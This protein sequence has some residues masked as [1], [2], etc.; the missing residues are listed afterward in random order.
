MKYMHAGNGG[1]YFGPNN[2]QLWNT[3]ERGTQSEEPWDEAACARLFD[4][5]RKILEDCIGKP[6]PSL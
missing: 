6:L 1:K 2:L 3:A 4:E 5:T